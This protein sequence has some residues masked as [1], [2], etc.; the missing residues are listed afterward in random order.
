MQYNFNIQHAT[1]APDGVEKLM[2]T[3]N[4]QYPARPSR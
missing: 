4:G 1:L 3:V 2:M